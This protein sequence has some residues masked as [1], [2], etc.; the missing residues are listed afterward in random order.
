[1]KSK[2]GY[3]TTGSSITAVTSG[4]TG[5][6]SV[7]FNEDNP[8]IS[9]LVM[10]Y[11]PVDDSYKV[12]HYDKDAANVIINT[13][14]ANFVGLGNN[15][16]E[17][18]FFGNF[19]VGMTI[20]TRQDFIKFGNSVSSGF[21]PCNKKCSRLRDICILIWQFY[22][23]TTPPLFIYGDVSQVIGVDQYEHID[24]TQISFTGAYKTYEITVSNINYQTIGTAETRSGVAK[25]Y[26]ALDIKGGDWVTNTNGQIVLNIVSVIEK[27]DVE[28]TFIARDLDMI[29]YKTYANS[30]F[31]IG[32]QI[33]I[34]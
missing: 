10:A 32:D 6:I 13:A 27:S 33:C 34:L 7:Q 14:S 28:I 4:A 22:D 24:D 9:I 8:P 5:S 20:D 29:V 25:Q 15:Q 12:H 31:S 2:T 19:T 16:Y 18:N 26:N 21:P 11:N 23:P 1:M 3:E 30:T 17:P